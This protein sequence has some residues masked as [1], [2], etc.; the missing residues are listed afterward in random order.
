M[1][2]QW[3]DAIVRAAAEA[4]RL[5]PMATFLFFAAL[6]LIVGQALAD[7]VQM[8]V[9]ASYR[10]ERFEAVRMLGRNLLEVAPA[11]PLLWALWQARRYLDKL[12]AGEV[13][14]PATMLMLGRVG[15]ALFSAALIG[16]F[17]APTLLEWIDLSVSF[18]ID[19]EPHYVALAG[20][21]LIMSLV[22]RVVRNVVEVAASLKAENEQIV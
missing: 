3:H 22:A 5:Q 18:R 11:V 12:A 1:D 21:G 19:G 9:G 6:V 20:L 15:E 4:S 2:K 13:W 16:M 17:I 14:G 10:E 8:L 7:P